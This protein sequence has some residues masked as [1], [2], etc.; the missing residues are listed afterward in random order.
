MEFGLELLDGGGIVVFFVDE[1]DAL[2]AGMAG[3]GGIVAKFVT[4][5]GSIGASHAGVG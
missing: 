2:S 3:H 5:Q 4:Y 1:G